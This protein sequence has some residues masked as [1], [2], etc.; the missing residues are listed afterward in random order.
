VEAVLPIPLQK[1]VGAL[2]GAQRQPNAPAIFS[3]HGGKVTVNLPAQSYKKA[4]IS[5]YA[6]SGKRVLRQKVSAAA[7]NSVSRRN[8][9]PGVYLLSVKGAGGGAP[10]TF[11]LT[12]GG[13]GLDINAAFN[14]ENVSPDRRLAKKAAAGEWTITVTADEVGYI[15]HIYEFLPMAGRDNPRQN[16]TLQEAPSGTY[17]VIVSSS[18]VGA[19]GSGNYAPGATVSISAGTAP[20]GYRFKNWAADNRGV[21][22]A[23]STDA[24][25]T[26][27]MTRTQ[28]TVTAVFEA[29]AFKA[30]R[31]LFSDS[32]DGKA[33]GYV[34]I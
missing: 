29:A 32:R 14:G 2:Y 15:P 20:A 4:E 28:V 27:T 12:H 30:A 19:S 13:G 11:R 16:I 5:L 24:A 26:F 9:A 22:F 6:A 25:T 3:N 1:T 8:V 7:A 10:L 34:T 21:I 33:Y 17:A 23:N 18:G 31:P